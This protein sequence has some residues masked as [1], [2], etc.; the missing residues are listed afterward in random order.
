MNKTEIIKPIDEKI[1]KYKKTYEH[2]L[3][4]VMIA[5]LKEIRE[6]LCARR[7]SHEQDD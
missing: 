3:V 5:D 4:Y 1:E 6:K 7:A 2:S